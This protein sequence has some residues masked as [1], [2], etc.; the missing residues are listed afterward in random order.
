M[1]NDDKTSPRRPSYYRGGLTHNAKLLA[2]DIP[3]V[4]SCT[5]PLRDIAKR[6]GVSVGAISAIRAR[7]TWRHI[8]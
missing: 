5:D 1:T 2:Q 3:L 4:R 8:P 6:F 7:R